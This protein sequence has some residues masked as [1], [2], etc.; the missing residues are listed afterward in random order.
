MIPRTVKKFCKEDPSLIENYYKAINDKTQTWDC[1]H[2]LETQLNLSKSE[3]IKQ[4][5][6]YNR[7]AVELIFL[8]RTEHTKLHHMHKKVS[9]ETRKKISEAM[10][11]EKNPLYG[12]KQSEETRKKMS[13]SKKGE[14]NP[15]YGL[16]GEKN[17]LYGKHK[18]EETRK[19]MSE[20]KKGEKHPLY[21]K[22]R[23]YHKDGSYHYA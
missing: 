4:D 3:L 22:H 13:E 8:T 2:R 18:S 20:S 1:H 10:T 7:P 19:K 12:K 17:P 21:G 9:A 14:K 11:G 6:Y 15:N 5:K 23:V 16:T